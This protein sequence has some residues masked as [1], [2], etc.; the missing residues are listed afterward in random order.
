MSN[1]IRLNGNGGYERKD[2]GVAGV[3][4]F[5]IG[6]AVVA[7][8]IHFV[9]A[10]L[11]NYLDKRFQAEQ[12]PVSPLANAPK[13]TRHL[14][15]SYADYLKQNFP[16]PQLEIDERTQLNSILLQQEQ[17]L[18][19]YGYI[20]EKA[21]I[22]RIPIERA[23][24]IIAQRGLPVRAQGNSEQARNTNPANTKEKKQ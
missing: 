11:Y 12:P 1:D 14:P 9:I 15:T 16:S 2:I 8:I 3:V 19:S 21:G 18:A 6:L 22:V 13:D 7:V 24:Q 10:G 23:M 5:L 20:D 4:Y 17:T